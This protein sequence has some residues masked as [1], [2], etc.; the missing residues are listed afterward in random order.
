MAGKGVECNC[1]KHPDRASIELGLSNRVALRVLSKRYGISIDSLHRHRHK[2]MSPQ[3]TAQLMQRGRLSEVDLEQLRITESEG[4]LHH[5]VATRGRLYKAMD[6]ADELGNH[7]DAARISGVLLK[8][9]ELTAK[10][11]GDLQTGSSQVNILVLPEYHGLRVAIMQALKMFPE[12]RAAVAQAL[13]NY[14]SPDVPALE[15]SA[16]R[17][18]AR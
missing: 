15:G 18:H 9:L 8:N 5:L 13:Q 17:V 3:L 16:Q 2:H 11:L 10:L 4:I 6:A 14:E 7:M 12:A 1:C